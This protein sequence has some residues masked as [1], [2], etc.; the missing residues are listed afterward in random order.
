MGLYI[1]FED[2]RLRVVGKVRFTEDEEDEDKMSVKLAN[3]LINEAEGRVEQD[4]SPRYAAPFST[5]DGGA[6]RLLPERPTKEI[7]RTL[8]ELQS[9]IRIL[10]TDFGK[11]GAVDGEKYSKNLKSAYD[12]MIKDMLVKKTDR[13]QEASGFA[14]PPLPGLKLNYM[15][16][17]ADDGFAG[18]IQ[19]ASGSA[20]QG[21]ATDQINSPSETFWRG[22]WNWR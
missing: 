10:D 16:Q 17:A 15:N 14:K 4:L 5:D 6:F 1:T 3:R 18:S 7:L 11:G 8:C 19:I 20:A 9:C 22:L 13:G 2:V 21:A 12:A